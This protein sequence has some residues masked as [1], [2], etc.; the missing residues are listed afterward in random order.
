MADFSCNHIRV[1]SNQG[2]ICVTATP[3]YNSSIL[4]DMFLEENAAFVKIVFLGWKDLEE[5]LLLLK[6]CFEKS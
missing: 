6:V 5:A 4:E 1:F 3:N 2:L